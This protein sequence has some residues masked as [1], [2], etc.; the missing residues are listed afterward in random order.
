MTSR[1]QWSIAAVA[2]A[3][4]WTGAAL[5]VLGRT[6]GSTRA[7]RQAAL[8]G[9]EIVLHPSFVTNHAITIDAPPDQIWPWLTQMGWHRAGWYTP[10][11]VDRL[12]FPANWPSADQLDPSLVRDLHR[13]DS[14][15][16]GP[17]GTASFVVERVE[18]PYLLVL[19][20]TTHLPPGWRER[21]GA[22]PDW[23]WTFH[24][25]AVIADP[26]D[27]SAI[28]TRLLIRNRGRLVPRWLDVAYHA[29]VVPADFVMAT[30]ML[31]GL[32]SRAEARLGSQSGRRTLLPHGLLE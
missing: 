24:L 31:R 29:L 21:Y 12:L 23:S 14:I 19:R 10:R 4:T 32:R 13:G 28:R 5:H 22:R 25:E 26:I 27:P 3:V 7:E 11:W 8:P 1:R 18:P 15:P 9:D 17:P 6:S 20:S 30:G 16:D 2:C